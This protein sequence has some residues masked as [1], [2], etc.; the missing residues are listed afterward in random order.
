MRRGIDSYIGRVHSERL[1]R[2]AAPLRCRAGTKWA[3]HVLSMTGA[4]AMR[5]ATIRSTETLPLSQAKLALA[6]HPSTD[7]DSS[8]ILATS[9][10]NF[11]TSASVQFQSAP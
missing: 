4:T 9:R 11:D 10:G 5:K 2:R 7:T 6:F 1:V 3:P 8:S